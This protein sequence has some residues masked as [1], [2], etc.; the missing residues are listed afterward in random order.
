[1]VASLRSGS[2]FSHG[3]EPAAYTFVHTV[4]YEERLPENSYYSNQVSQSVPF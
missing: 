2:V 1:M 3:K 4:G